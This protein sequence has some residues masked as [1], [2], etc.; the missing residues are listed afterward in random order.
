MHRNVVFTF[1]LIVYF[2]VVT[3]ALTNFDVGLFTSAIIL[4][5]LPTFLLARFSAAPS[6]LLLAVTCFAVGMAFLL[7]GAAYAYGLWYT[8]S[9]VGVEIMGFLSLEI[10]LITLMKII[11][12]VLFYELLFDDGLY[13]LSKA[14]NN[15]VEFGVFGISAAVLVGVISLLFDN[16]NDSNAYYW[17]TI[18]LLLSS[19]AMLSLRQALTLRLINKIV[20]FVGVAMIPML[21]IEL[22]IVSGGHKVIIPMLYT[23]SFPFTNTSLSIPDFLLAISI[24]A[25]VIVVYE[26]YLD[27]SL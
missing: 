12:L 6:V 11:F 2:V 18:I 20:H 15:F 22:L 19:L 13:S 7:E 14:R 24:P 23:F 9:S 21:C 16:F 3:I 26:L 8:S 5:G 25:F 1:G 4:L 27:D 10:F 17:I